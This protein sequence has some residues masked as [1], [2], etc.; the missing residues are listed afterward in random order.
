MLKVLNSSD[1][2]W[3]GSLFLSH[4]NGN[5]GSLHQG[6]HALQVIQA[7]ETFPSRWSETQ[8]ARTIF[9]RVV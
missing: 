8:L 7:A 6:W 1:S 9:Q 5:A 4:S 3:K 2:G